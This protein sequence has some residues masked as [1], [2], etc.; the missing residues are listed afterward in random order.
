MSQRTAMLVA[1]AL[2]VFVV[3]ALV[4]VVWQLFQ[5][6]NVDTLGLQVAA[7]AQATEI[8]GDT[9][10]VSGPTDAEIAAREASFQQL[11]Q[12]ANQKLEES[13]KQQQE[14]TKQLAAEKSKQVAVNAPAAAP[15]QANQQPK[16]NLSADQAA[17][18]ALKA[19]KGA[20]LVKTPELISFKGTAAFEV[21]LDRGVV[22]IDANT[23]EVLYDSAVVI[24]VHDSGGGGGNSGGNPAVSAPKVASTSHEH[25]HESHDKGQE[26][27][28]TEQHKSESEHGD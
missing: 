25:E 11:I 2:T 14:L 20:M 22:Y 1:T 6:S 26:S 19:E 28:P 12:Q 8:V 4:S 16:Y 18:L 9:H 27:H 15:A 23:G 10:A 5:K 17:A 21:T 3:I 24:I 13:Y 7:P